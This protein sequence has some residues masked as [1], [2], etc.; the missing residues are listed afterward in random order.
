MHKIS[1]CD[2]ASGHCVLCVRLYGG[3]QSLQ[4][5]STTN[6][7]TDSSIAKTGGLRL[8]SLRFSWFDLRWLHLSNLRIS[9]CAKTICNPWIKFGYTS[10]VY[11]SSALPTMTC[12]ASRMSGSTAKDLEQCHSCY[13]ST[14]CLLWSGNLGSAHRQAPLQCFT[15]AGTRFRFHRL[16]QILSELDTQSVCH[17]QHSHQNP[18]SFSIDAH[19]KNTIF[20]KESG[21]WWDYPPGL[22]EHVPT[23]HLILLLQ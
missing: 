21:C 1:A 7:R 13:V 17:P 23:W 18:Q 20:R 14:H 12:E 9:V 22:A 19:K 5:T 8:R 2:R 15:F 6:P 4:P 3:V 11:K 16:F 10:E